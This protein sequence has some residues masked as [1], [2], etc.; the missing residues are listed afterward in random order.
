MNGIRANGEPS[1]K[2]VAVAAL[3]S[4]VSVPPM[5]AV[6]ASG[7]LRVNGI[8]ANGEPS[9]KDG[10]PLPLW[11][12]NSRRERNRNQ[13]RTATD[14]GGKTIVLQ[15]EAQRKIHGLCYR[16]PTGKA[17]AVRPMVN[18]V[19]L[20]W[21]SHS[22][23]LP[24]LRKRLPLLCVRSPD[25]CRWCYW[26]P[27]S[28]R[29]RSQRRTQ[30]AKIES[31]CLDCSLIGVASI[32]GTALPWWCRNPRSER[33]QSQREPSGKDRKPLPLWCLNPRRERNHNQRGTKRQR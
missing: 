1:G 15:L 29:D 23:T 11:C 27:R 24:L 21:C 25:C 18:V 7:T 6:A 9:G 2:T 4:C 20:P 26:N 32:N 22:R 12:L 10:K 19:A 3:R 33:D 17:V 14:K 8:A 13:L 28:E 5:V 31:P 30:A 16:E